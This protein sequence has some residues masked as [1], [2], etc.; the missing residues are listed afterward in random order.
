MQKTLGFGKKW[1]L[2][3][4]TTDSPFKRGLHPYQKLACLV[5]YLKIVNIFL[6]SNICIL[7]QI[8]QESQKWH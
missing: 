5:L 1:R 7:K 6:K 2:E 4:T 3:L 8:V